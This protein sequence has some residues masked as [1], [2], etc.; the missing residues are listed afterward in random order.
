MICAI[1][2]DLT[3]VMRYA[4]VTRFR[5]ND[6]TVIL[7]GAQHGRA[8]QGVVEYLT[9]QNRLLRLFERPEFGLPEEIPD[10]FQV[11][12]RVPIA[13]QKGESTPITPD[14]EVVAIRIKN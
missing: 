11:I 2:P 1:A 9:D 12:F 3:K 7:V 8:V 6:Q 4:V 5:H 13:R 10:N 14:I